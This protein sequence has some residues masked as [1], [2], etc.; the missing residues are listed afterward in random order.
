[1]ATRK[2]DEARARAA[3]RTTPMR[4]AATSNRRRPAANLTDEPAPPARATRAR[5]RARVEPKRVPKTA[6]AKVEDPW[7]RRVDPAQVALAVVVVALLLCVLL[8][9]DVY[10]GRN[11]P[12]H[13]LMVTAL[14]PLAFLVPVGAGVFV[15]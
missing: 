14:G 7:Q 4:A 11:D 5:E 8:L 12:V 9:A 13:V 3:T 15:L 1:M 2:T 10:L 6:V